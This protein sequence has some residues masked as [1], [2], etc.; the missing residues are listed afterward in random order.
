[1]FRI[2][3]ALVSAIT[4]VGCAFSDDV[5]A[6]RYEPSGK[7]EVAQ[8]GLVSVLVDDG[9]TIDRNR[10]STKIGGY[11]E[12]LGAVRSATPIVD[13]VRAAL[14]VEFERRGYRVEPGG[15][16]VSATIKRFYNDYTLGVVGGGERGEVELTVAIGDPSGDKLFVQPYAGIW[17]NQVLM[18]NASNAAE[19]VALAL[20]DALD[21]MFADPGFRQALA[22]R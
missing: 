6:I 22:D 14:Q 11:G 21:K 9:R 12:K 1:M 20:R 19:S 3:T 17:Q 7:T 10:I 13:V 8:A 16:T 4:L 15:R 18:T 5:V 2:L